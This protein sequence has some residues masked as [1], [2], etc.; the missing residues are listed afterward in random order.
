MAFTQ[1]HKKVW[2]NFQK[3]GSIWHTVG[4]CEQCMHVSN[5]SSLVCIQASGHYWEK[6]LIYV[7]P[8]FPAKSQYPTQLISSSPK[9]A[10]ER[11]SSKSSIEE[12]PGNGSHGMLV[13]MYYTGMLYSNFFTY[14]G[15]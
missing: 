11:H 14:K 3:G 10:Y 2:F 9:V 6:I 13:H 15:V 8:V 4:T 12:V 5:C 1:K 7:P